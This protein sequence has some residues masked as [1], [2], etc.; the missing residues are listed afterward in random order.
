[1]R[2][3]GSFTALACLASASPGWRGVPSAIARKQARQ[4]R[5][6]YTAP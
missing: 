3:A 6:A 2:H 4:G 1:M 5:T